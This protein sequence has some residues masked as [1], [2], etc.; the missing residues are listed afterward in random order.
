MLGGDVMLSFSYIKDYESI[1]CARHRLIEIRNKTIRELYK[2]KSFSILELCYM[3]QISVCRIREILGE[4]DADINYYDKVSLDEADIAR[5]NTY[6]EEVLSVKLKSEYSLNDFDII[7]IKYKIVDADLVDES[8]MYLQFLDVIYHATWYL[9]DDDEESDEVDNEDILGE[10]L[11]TCRLERYGLANINKAIIEENVNLEKTISSLKKELAEVKQKLIEKEKTTSETV[12][13]VQEN[14]TESIPCK[15]ILSVSEDD[16]DILD[17]D[18]WDED[19]SE[20][21]KVSVESSKIGIPY[22]SDFERKFTDDEEDIMVREYKCNRNILS[23]ELVYNVG[24][25]IG[26]ELKKNTYREILIRKKEYVFGHKTKKQ[27]VH[28]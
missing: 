19:S 7:F 22:C 11:N 28:R 8:G 20:D 9:N 14:V 2:D 4:M 16:F 13:M 27:S 15:G 24:A 12:V 26:K 6:Y 3:F 23:K 10:M 21:E 5:L 25:R 17:D 1:S 18:F